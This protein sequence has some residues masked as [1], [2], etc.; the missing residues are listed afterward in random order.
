MSS[1]GNGSGRWVVALAAALL[2]VGVAAP[3]EAKD[4]FEHA[5]KHELGRIAAHEAVYAGRH[6]LGAVILGSRGHH[7]GYGRHPYGYGHSGHHRGRHRGH[8]HRHHYGY[9]HGYYTGHY[10]G[11]YGPV[12]VV[13]H[14]HHHY[15]YSGCGHGDG[16]Y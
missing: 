13:H 15:H 1:R 2:L 9:H 12:R 8:G 4:E 14:E 6:I 7:G 3:A 11:H 5:F 10:D 16:E